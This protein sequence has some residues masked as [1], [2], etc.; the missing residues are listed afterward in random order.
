MSHSIQQREPL[1]TWE[2][3]HHSTRRS[4]RI[5]RAS[6]NTCHALCGVHSSQP[7]ENSTSIRDVLLEFSSEEPEV[8][9]A[10]VLWRSILEKQ[11]RILRSEED[12]KQVSSSDRFRA[13]FSAVGE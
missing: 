12:T 7:S 4:F 9:L 5:T 2:A 13:A 1:A 8:S 11:R 3:T 10:Q 6:A